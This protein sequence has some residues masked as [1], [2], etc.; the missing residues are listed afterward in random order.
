[1]ARS[2]M[3]QKD[4]LTVQLNEA[5]ED[6]RGQ[7]RDQDRW[8]EQENIYKPI[9]VKSNSNTI[10]LQYSDKAARPSS[11]PAA[12]RWSGWHRNKHV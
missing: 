4:K 2:D 5:R 3:Q 7:Q 1:M 6:R 10:Q 12:G 9:G 11:G 8:P